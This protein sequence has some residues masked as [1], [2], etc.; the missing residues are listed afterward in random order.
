MSETGIEI[1]FDVHV[2]L[3]DLQGPTSTHDFL[4]NFEIV[5]EIDGAK[6]VVGGEPKHF[7]PCAAGKH[8]VDARIRSRSGLRPEWMLEGHAALFAAAEVI[9]AEGTLARFRYVGDAGWFLSGKGRLE[10]FAS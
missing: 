9:V 2:P 6:H 8:R 7:F 5:V 10:P 1:E 3:D 4:R